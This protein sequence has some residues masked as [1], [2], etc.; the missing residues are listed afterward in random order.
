MVDVA[1]VLI[2]AEEIDAKLAEIGRAIT[3]ETSSVRL[4]RQMAVEAGGAK[5]WRGR[6]DDGGDE[7]DDGNG[8][9]D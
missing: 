5:R 9:D 4:G 8:G 1:R 7:D 3:E 2:S 6:C